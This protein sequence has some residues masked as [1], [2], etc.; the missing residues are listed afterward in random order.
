MYQCSLVASSMN[1]GHSIKCYRNSNIEGQKVETKR[2]LEP[3]GLVAQ[4]KSLLR[5]SSKR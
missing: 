2:L 5:N 1:N 3:L 4:F